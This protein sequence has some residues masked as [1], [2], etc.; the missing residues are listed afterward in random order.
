LFLVLLKFSKII[1][2][3]SKVERKKKISSASWCQSQ[4]TF[5]YLSLAELQ[6]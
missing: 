6:K 2:F 1:S 5:F 4:K 3:F